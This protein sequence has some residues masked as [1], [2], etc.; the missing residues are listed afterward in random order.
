MRLMDPKI[1][2]RS[3]IKVIGM[4]STMHHNQY[5]N[6]IALWKR[7]SPQKKRIQNTINEDLIAIQVYSHFNTIEN[8]FDIWACV[9][10]SSLDSIPEGMTSFTIPKGAYAVFLHKGLDASKTYQQIISE[11]LPNSGYEFD[12]RPHF[13]VMG[14]KYKNGSADSEEDFYVPIRVKC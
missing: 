9:E 13:Q 4:Q 14:T 6:I 5:G 12:D 3:E 10:V 2:Q 1:M 7:F 11:W 8:P